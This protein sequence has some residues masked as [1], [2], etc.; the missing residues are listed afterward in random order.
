MTVWKI[1]QSYFIHPG[2]GLL[3]N[4]Q[5][6]SI[7]S[8]RKPPQKANPPESPPPRQGR[9]M[10]SSTNIENIEDIEMC[11]ESLSSE[12]SFLRPLCPSESGSNGKVSCYKVWP[13]ET[14]SWQDKNVWVLS[15]SFFPTSFTYMA[16]S[17]PAPDSRPAGPPDPTRAFPAMEP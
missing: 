17:S 2:I 12:K 9:D 3:M 6:Y 1:D 14:L 15:K 5:R 13:R 10:V 4:T 11:S 8:P 7:A 16:R